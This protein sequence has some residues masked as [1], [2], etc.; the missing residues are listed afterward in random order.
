[1]KFT[2]TISDTAE[3]FLTELW[4]A[5]PD[6]D[7]VTAAQHHIDSIL[8]QNPFRGIVEREGLRRLVVPPLSVVFEIEPE[9]KI[10][11]ITGVARMP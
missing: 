6:R 9:E 11:R 2:V 10:V 3:S 8:A 1:M 5:G 4:L 7:A